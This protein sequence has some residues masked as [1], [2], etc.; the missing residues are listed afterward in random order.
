M[1][2]D[3]QQ[4]VDL[5]RMHC[6]D[7]RV[8]VDLGAAA[9]EDLP[10]Y[11]AQFPDA[12]VVGIE[13]N[14]KVYAEYALMNPSNVEYHREVIGCGFAVRPF[15]LKDSWGVSGL[16]DRGPE[17]GTEVQGLPMIPLDHFCVVHNINEISAIKIDVEGATLDVLE[18]T[19]GILRTVK[20]MHVETETVEYF[21]GQRLHDEV[22]RFLVAAGFMPIA[23]HGDLGQHQYDSV[24]VPTMG[25]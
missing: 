4:F 22:V 15:Y 7:A 23:M 17:H 24:W 21:K 20:I 11:K 14:P 1:G 12:R 13:G 2:I 5:M 18:G 9:G 3:R 10:F 19:H 16:Y 6:P 8:I 25:G